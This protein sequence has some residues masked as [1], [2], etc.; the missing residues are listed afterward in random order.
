MISCLFWKFLHISQ[1]NSRKIMNLMKIDS[2]Q[3]FK[4]R[5]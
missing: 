4:N 3:L 1:K 5:I 2:C